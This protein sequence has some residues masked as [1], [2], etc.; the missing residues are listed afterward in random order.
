M[1][2]GQVLTANFINAPDVQDELD[3]LLARLPIRAR[4]TTQVVKNA[5]ITFSDL[6]G[7]SAPVAANKRYRL[8]GRL[9]VQAAD[10]V[11]DMKAQ[12]TLPAGA[13]IEWSMYAPGTT[14][15][16][17]ETTIITDTSTTFHVRGTIAGTTTFRFEGWIVTAAAAG[18]AQA[19]GA[20]NTSTG[21]G[22]VFLANSEFSLEEWI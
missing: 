1:A 19:Q 16:S 21:G 9:I 10:G 12:F 8:R 3:A 2:L 17:V 15:A 4:Q 6:T 18:T 11:M 20:Q 5:S 7:L 14:A 22:L 13:T